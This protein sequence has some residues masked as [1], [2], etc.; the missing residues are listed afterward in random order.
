MLGKVYKHCLVE[1]I[2]MKKLIKKWGN[3]HVIVLNVEDMEI[4]KLKEGDVVIV[5]LFKSHVQGIPS[6]P[7]KVK[8][9]DED[10]EYLKR[11]WSYPLPKR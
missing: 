9:E 6:I 8:G 7:L 2:K 4:C 10:G 1:I 3:T 11:G 5:K